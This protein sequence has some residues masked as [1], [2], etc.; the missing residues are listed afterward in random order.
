MDDMN[1]HT[2]MSTRQ[3]QLN[4]EAEQWR[5]KQLTQAKDAKQNN[6]AF[7]APALAKIGEVMVETGSKLQAKYNKALDELSSAEQSTI[8]PARS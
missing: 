7:Y 4:A 1:L 2:H 8:K 6:E 3:Q 5:M